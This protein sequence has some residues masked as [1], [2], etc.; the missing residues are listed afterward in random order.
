MDANKSAQASFLS[1]FEGWQ[2]NYFQPGETAE[3]GA[4]GSDPEGDGIPNLLEY[5]LNLHPRQPSPVGLPTL[6]SDPNTLSL[7]YRKDPSKPDIGWQVEVSSNLNT[8]DQVGDSLIGNDGTIEIRRASV[9]TDGSRKFL[10]L[11]VTKLF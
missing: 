11:K 9:P 1:P 2:T 4:P 8:W 10:R 7:T 3:V 5:A 6:G